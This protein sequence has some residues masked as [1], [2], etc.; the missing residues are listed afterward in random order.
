MLES[1]SKRMN[2]FS[3]I[4]SF[5]G[6]GG[7]FSIVLGW[8]ELEAEFF[9]STANS[10]FTKILFSTKD[11]SPRTAIFHSLCKL[12]QNSDI[13]RMKTFSSRELDSFLR[14]ENH[15]PCMSSGFPDA[16]IKEFTS[17][18]LAGHFEFLLAGEVEDWSVGSESTFVEKLEAIND[19]FAI[20]VN[21]L[22]HFNLLN[23]EVNLVHLTDTNIYVEFKSSVNGLKLG[24][25]SI[26]K[27]MTFALERV[28]RRIIGRPSI[29]L[30]AE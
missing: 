14:D 28:V 16:E 4:D 8:N 10:R 1:F 21:V 26:D 22:D 11:K 25:N 3:K 20:K 27:E 12:L 6:Q 24:A 15:I 9:I 13:D 17:K 2:E 29:I 18:L 5:V 23:L 7:D 30:V 19:F